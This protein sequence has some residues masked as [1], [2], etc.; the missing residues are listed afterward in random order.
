MGE[1]RGDCRV[2]VIAFN[3]DTYVLLKGQAGRA[4]E[5]HGA[6]YGRAR[7]WTVTMAKPEGQEEI[8]SV[9]VTSLRPQAES[10][11]TTRCTTGVPVQG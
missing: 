1:G 6:V 11:H 8:A 10:E 4:E 3:L 9:W 7:W 2:Q 5:G